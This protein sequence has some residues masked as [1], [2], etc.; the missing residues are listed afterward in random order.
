[1]FLVE[2]GLEGERPEAAMADPGEHPHGR[3]LDLKFVERAVHQPAT[4][5]IRQTIG[6][7]S[8]QLIKPIDAL[9]KRC[10]G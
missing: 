4:P 7:K 1:M 5:L 9:T 3:G 10:V 2:D 6:K 8:G